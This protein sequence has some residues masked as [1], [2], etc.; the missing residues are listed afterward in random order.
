MISRGVII[1]LGIA[2]LT[3]IGLFMVKYQVRALEAQLLEINRKVVSNQEATHIL[4]AEWAHLNDATR[5]EQLN[6]RYLSLQPITPAQLGRIDAIPMRPVRIE[7]P[8]ATVSATTGYGSIDDLLKATN[9][10]EGAPQ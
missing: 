4:K 6:A 9:V 5:I 2:I 10:S 7:Q 8:V 1:W 3:G